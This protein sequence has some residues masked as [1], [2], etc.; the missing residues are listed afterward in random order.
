VSAQRG[1][2][3]ERRRKAFEVYNGGPVTEMQKAIA[4]RRAERPLASLCTLCSR[5]GCVHSMFMSSCVM[6]K[7]PQCER[8]EKEH[9]ERAC[10]P[11]SC[12]GEEVRP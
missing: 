3:F 4:D 11:P 7:A 9:P 8:C 1:I 2:A 10:T 6:F 12:L 5:K